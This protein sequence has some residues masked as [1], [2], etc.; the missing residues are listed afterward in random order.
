MRKTNRSKNDYALCCDLVIASEDARIGTPYSRMWGAYLSGMWIYRLGLTLRK[1]IRAYRQGTIGL[2]S[3]KNRTN[4]C[5]GAI[6]EARGHSA[7][8]G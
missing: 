5:R 8:V 3:G 1:G 2:G 4:Q 6:R 7:E